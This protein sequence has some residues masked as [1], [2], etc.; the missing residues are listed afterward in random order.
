MQSIHRLGKNVDSNTN[1]QV[2]LKCQA[3][4]SSTQ[5]TSTKMVFTTA[6]K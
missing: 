4:G 3:T 1:L 5:N 6:E 2:S